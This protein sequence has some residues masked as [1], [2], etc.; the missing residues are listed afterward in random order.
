MG[1]CV[2][3]VGKLEESA[4]LEKPGYSRNLIAGLN[5]MLS[6]SEW[7]SSQ[8]QGEAVRLRI[9]ASLRSLNTCWGHNAKDRRPTSKAHANDLIQLL[10]AHGLFPDHHPQSKGQQ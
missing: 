6:S 9:S 2:V 7:L 3:Q 8:G 1:D 5:S 4:G 10:P